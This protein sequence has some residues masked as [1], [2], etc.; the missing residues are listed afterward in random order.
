[1]PHVVRAT[2]GS[3]YS[4][5]F[6]FFVFFVNFVAISKASQLPNAASAFGSLELDI[7]SYD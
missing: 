4:L 6:V 5:D 1:M 7:G 3:A 2:R